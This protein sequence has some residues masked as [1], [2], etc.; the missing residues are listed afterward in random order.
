MKEPIR[1]IKPP[2]TWK[3]LRVLPRLDG[4]I[5]SPCS[6]DHVGMI[7]EWATEYNIT[8]NIISFGFSTFERRKRAKAARIEPPIIQ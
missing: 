7:I 2:I 5:Q 1:P 6:A 4:F 3:R 8:K